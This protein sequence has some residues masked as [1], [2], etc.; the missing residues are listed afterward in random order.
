[1]SYD[2]NLTN[3]SVYNATNSHYKYDVHVG[4]EYLTTVLYTATLVQYTIPPYNG[5]V[6][7][8][9]VHSFV[10]GDQINI[11]QGVGGIAANPGMEGLFT[12]LVAGVGFIV[13]NSL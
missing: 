7:I 12:V 2:L 10:V 6:Q 1:M 5:R 13:V 11:I 3:T 8:N 4:E 9:V